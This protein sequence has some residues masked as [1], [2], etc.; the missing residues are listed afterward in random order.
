MRSKKQ[1]SYPIH[2]VKCPWCETHNDCRSLDD[3]GIPGTPQTMLEKGLK[4]ECDGCRRLVEVVSSKQ[5]TV[6]R[7]RQYHG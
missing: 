5:I 7:V 1:P 3:I 2:A 4:F 6:V